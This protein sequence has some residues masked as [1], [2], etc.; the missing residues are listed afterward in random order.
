MLLS[1]T[2]YFLIPLLRPV[3]YKVLRNGP[4]VTLSHSSLQCN[5]CARHFCRLRTPMVVQKRLGKKNAVEKTNR[6]ALR[7]KANTGDSNYCSFRKRNTALNTTVENRLR[8]Y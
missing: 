2:F 5:I 6:Y 7:S 8:S 1:M 4:L 3:G